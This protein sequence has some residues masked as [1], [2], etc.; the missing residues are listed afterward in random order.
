MKLYA[1]TLTG[2]G[3]GIDVLLTG[4][5]REDGAKI[6]HAVEVMLPTGCAHVDGCGEPLK[7]PSGGQLLWAAPGDILADDGAAISREVLRV[8]IARVRE[9]RHADMLRGPLGDNWP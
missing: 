1:R 7:A 8:E 3:L 6:L 5:V 4:H 2:A 9:R